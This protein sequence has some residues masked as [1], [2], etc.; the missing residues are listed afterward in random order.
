[1]GEIKKRFT[2]PSS[3]T[4]KCIYRV[5]LLMVQNLNVSVKPC[6]LGVHIMPIDKLFSFC[7]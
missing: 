6:V 2:V 4:G 1:M 5:L 3:L 7:W